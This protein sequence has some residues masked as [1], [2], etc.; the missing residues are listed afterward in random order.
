M[1]GAFHLS[2]KLERAIFLLVA[3]TVKRLFTSVVY[4]HL[5]RKEFEIIPEEEVEE[6]GRVQKRC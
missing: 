2:W 3:W 6:Q 5:E 4:F 1:I